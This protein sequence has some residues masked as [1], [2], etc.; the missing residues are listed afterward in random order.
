MSSITAISIVITIVAVKLG[1]D[2]NSAKV[3]VIVTEL[4]LRETSE[5]GTKWKEWQPAHAYP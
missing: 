1:C 5:R 3:H 2:V 4:G